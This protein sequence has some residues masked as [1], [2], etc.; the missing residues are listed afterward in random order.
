MYGD[1]HCNYNLNIKVVDARAS[2]TLYANSKPTLNSV[3]LLAAPKMVARDFERAKYAASA[4]PTNSFD[5]APLWVCFRVG[6]ETPPLVLVLQSPLASVICCLFL[7][8]RTSPNRS[9]VTADVFN[10]ARAVLYCRSAPLSQTTFNYNG[11]GNGN[12]MDTT[13]DPTLVLGM[14]INSGKTLVRLPR[15]RR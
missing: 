9:H 5:D 11:N 7:L 14:G 3:P 1:D 13:G 4:R 6:Q 15:E 8:F 2:R 10:F 12:S